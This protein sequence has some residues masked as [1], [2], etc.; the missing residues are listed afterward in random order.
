MYFL[1]Q[2]V[3]VFL[4]CPGWKTAIPLGGDIVGILP[5]VP[6]PSS[7]R[8]AWDAIMNGKKG[9]PKIP[10]IPKRPL[11]MDQYGN[12]IPDTS[13]PHTQL[14]TRYSARR[15]ESYRQAREWGENGQLL[16]DVDFTNHGRPRNHANPHQHLYNPA[17]GAREAGI[18]LEE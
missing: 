3:G 15:E 13:A 5:V 1:W 6:S 7:A 14:G 10:Y 16:R 18:P 11:P 8:A 12:K 9:I 2:D 4:K 17:T